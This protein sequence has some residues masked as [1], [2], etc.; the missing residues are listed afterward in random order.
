MEKDNPVTY[1]FLHTSSNDY[2]L[3]N[4]ERLAKRHSTE[5]S[6]ESFNKNWKGNRPVIRVDRA[7]ID[8]NWIVLICKEDN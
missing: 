3:T 5:Q 6:A 8:F 7:F 2:S 4:G 1:L